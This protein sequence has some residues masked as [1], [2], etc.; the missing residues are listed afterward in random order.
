MNVVRAFVGHS[1]TED[2]EKLNN[3]FLKYLDQIKEMQIGFTWDHAKAA[4]PKELAEKV[5]SLVRDKNLFIGICTKKE[6]VIFP[7]KLERCWIRRKIIGSHERE[8]LWKTSDWILQEIGLAVGREMDL[9]LLVEEG[10]RTLGGLQGNIEYI[11]FNRNFPERSFG[12]I[13]EMIRSLIPRSVGIPVPELETAIPKNS[14]KEQ[15]K[16]EAEK[17]WS[18]P[19]PE[20]DSLIFRFALRMSIKTGNSEAEKRI[21][22]AFMQS[23][24][25]CTSEGVASWTAFDQYTRLSIGKDGSLSKLEQLEKDKPEVSDVQFYLGCAY[26]IYKEYDKAGQAYIQAGL[27]SPDIQK[28]L[29]NFGEAAKTYCRGGLK[30]KTEEVVEKMRKELV[31]SGIGEETFIETLLEIA[32]IKDDTDVFYGLSERLLDLKPGDAETRFNLAY[33]YSQGSQEKLSLFH[34]LRIPEGERGSGAWNNLG[35]Q[36]E[37]LDIV[38]CSINSYRKAEQAGSTIS[39]SNIA[40]RFIKVGFLEEAE[41]ICTRAITIKEYHNNVNHSMAKIKD[42]PEEESK[43]EAKI[44][45]EV[46]PYSDF[47]KAYGKALCKDNPVDCVGIWEGPKC[48]LSLKIQDGYLQAEGIY[49]VSQNNNLGGLGINMS[50]S[51][52]EQ[53]KTS[54]K[55]IV[56]YVGTLSGYSIKGL[57]SDEPQNNKLS[58]KAGILL[59]AIIKRTERQIL[60]VFCDSLNEIK[61]YDKDAPETERLYSLRKISD[62]VESAESRKSIKK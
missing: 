50:Y 3:T 12:K 54:D 53:P 60:M 14:V 47:Y 42:M 21:T 39:M 8:F 45:K 17:W 49:E 48:Q 37:R 6:R 9:I 2:D 20:W 55:R 5:M 28:R 25:G 51:V 62:I 58:S 16:E 15:K 46:T 35:V 1:F 22:S 13:L 36:Y 61:I 29:K 56:K 10:L 26:E 18:E 44:L 11:E 38:G 43:K 57:I 34:Y 40:N 4:E 32:R 33:R 41:E 27:C 30:L 31:T 24:E 7:N 19:K 52:E 23:P 59:N